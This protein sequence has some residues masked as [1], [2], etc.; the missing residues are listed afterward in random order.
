MRKN[1]IQP[2]SEVMAVRFIDM[3]CDTSAYVPVSDKSFDQE[4]QVF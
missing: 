3:I 1:Y 4:D 2:A